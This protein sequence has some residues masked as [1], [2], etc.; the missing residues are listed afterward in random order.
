MHCSHNPEFNARARH[1][2]F[3]VAPGEA[4]RILNHLKPLLALLALDDATGEGNVPRGSSCSG[5]VY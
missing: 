4:S 2:E 3:D 5:L 1:V